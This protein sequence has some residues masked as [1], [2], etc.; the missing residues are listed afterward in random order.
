V[1]VQ[2]PTHPLASQPREQT[3]CPLIGPP[4]PAVDLQDPRRSAHRA[5]L[6]ARSSS[7]AGRHLHERSHTTRFPSESLPKRAMRYHG[8]LARHAARSRR[9]SNSLVVEPQPIIVGQPMNGDD[10]E[11]TR[12]P[13]SRNPSIAAATRRVTEPRSGSATPPW[14]PIR[15]RG[16][17]PRQRPRARTGLWPPDWTPLSKSTCGW[18]AARVLGRADLEP[19]VRR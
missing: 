4:G 15:P 2:G 16:R 6:A 3:S 10:G 8:G 17:G 18:T 1:E 13:A 12:R 11:N 5:H 7:L 19:E 14:I 9:R